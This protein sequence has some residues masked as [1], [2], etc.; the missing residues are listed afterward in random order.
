MAKQEDFVQL[1]IESP[2]EFQ[3]DEGEIESECGDDLVIDTEK[4][5]NQGDS[6]SSKTE[7]KRVT[8]RSRKHRRRKRKAR[9]LSTTTEE[10][11]IEEDTKKQSEDVPVV[12][13]QHNCAAPRLEIADDRQPFTLKKTCFLKMSPQR[14]YKINPKEVA[15]IYFEGVSIPENF[16]GHIFPAAELHYKNIKADPCTVFGAQRKQG[17]WVRFLNNGLD[18]VVVRKRDPAL[19]MHLSKAEPFFVTHTY[20]YANVSQ[21]SQMGVPAERSYPHRDIYRDHPHYTYYRE[22]SASPSYRNW[23]R[24]TERDRRH[25]HYQQRRGRENQ[26]NRHHLPSPPHQDTT[27]RNNY[28]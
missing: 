23:R 7:E 16:V 19:V 12:Q 11:E 17:F 24:R 5:E 3:S 9:K 25:H 26:N 18:Q 22:R 14:D 13:L 2:R 27:T 6:S 21:A 28:C 1:H 4:Q 20:R 10:E 15:K 8:R